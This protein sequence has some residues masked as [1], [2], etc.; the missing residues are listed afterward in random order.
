MQFSL[1]MQLQKALIQFLEEDK[2]EPEFAC[3][4]FSCLAC[5]NPEIRG[6]EIIRLRSVKVVFRYNSV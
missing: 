3:N 2:F 5:R 6:T 1:E 4:E